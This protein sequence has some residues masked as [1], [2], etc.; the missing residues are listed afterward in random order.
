MILPMYL[1]PSE[2]LYRAVAVHGTKDSSTHLHLF[3]RLLL[4]KLPPNETLSGIYGVGGVGDGLPLGRQAHEHLV[5]LAEANDRWRGPDTLCILY[6]LGFLQTSTC[7]RRAGTRYA[8]VKSLLVLLARDQSLLL[9]RNG[10]GHGTYPCRKS[11]IVD[12]TNM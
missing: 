9:L 11:K 1:P 10:T 2:T 3:L 8:S 5:V 6:H 4:V 12:T 7:K